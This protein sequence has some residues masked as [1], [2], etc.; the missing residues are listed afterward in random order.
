MDQQTVTL[1]RRQSLSPGDKIA[2]VGSGISGL[3]CAWLLAQRYHVT[4]FEAGAYFGGHSNTVDV[5][6]ENITHP[7]VTGFLVHN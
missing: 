1:A 3:A 4:L 5:H 7:V 2:V 6:L